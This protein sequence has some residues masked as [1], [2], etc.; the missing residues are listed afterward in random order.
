MNKKST[1]VFYI[2]STLTALLVTQTLYL[3]S[4]ESMKASAQEKKVLFV[5]LTGLP[6]LA[7]SSDSAYI[8][9]RSLSFISDIYH[10]DGCLR[11]YD[12]STYAIENSTV[13]SIN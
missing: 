11:E 1:F 4:Q 12:K 3:S 5:K 13:T 8:R 6:D 2:F 7:L 9:H 10:L